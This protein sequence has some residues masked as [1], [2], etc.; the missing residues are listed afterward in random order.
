MQW[1]PCRATPE[2]LHA[3]LRSHSILTWQVKVGLLEA[4]R[5]QDLGTTVDLR[6]RASPEPGK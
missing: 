3:A 5:M 4:K 1:A 6:A 2:G